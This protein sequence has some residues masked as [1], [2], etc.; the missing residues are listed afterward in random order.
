MFNKKN[1]CDICHSFDAEIY[2]NKGKTIYYKCK[3]CGGV[4][5]S[6]KMEQKFYLENKTYL[7]NPEDYVSLIDP[8]GFIWLLGKFE[9]AYNNK[10]N[11]SRGNLLEIGAGVGYFMM[12]AFARGWNPEGI[13]TSKAA[14]EWGQ[15]NL[16][17]D[18]KNT[19]LELFSSEKKY[20]AFVLIEVLEHFHNA[21]YAMKNIKELVNS[22]AMIFG[23]TPNVE[24][25][26]WNDERDIFDPNDHIYLF[27]EKCLRVLCKE[28]GAKELSVEYFGGDNGDAHLLYSCVI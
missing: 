27:S 13:E 22:P 9:E 14:A 21:N 24:S 17:M 12:L 3:H 7:T 11:K 8:K 19:T 25:N 15:K 10:I 5:V 4:F 26:Y 28:L 18:I 20:D 23:T 1:K 16:R 2:I 6:P